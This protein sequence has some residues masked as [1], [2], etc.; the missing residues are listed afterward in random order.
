MYAYATITLEHPNAMTL[1]ASAIVTQGDITKGYESYCFVVEEG[2][3]RRIPIQTGT[4]AANRIQVLK[5]QETRDGKTRW[6]DFTGEEI[7][8]QENVPSLSDGQ[9]VTASPSEK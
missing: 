3:L 7:I 6:V 8:V 5:K 1:P 4:R 2:K 9:A